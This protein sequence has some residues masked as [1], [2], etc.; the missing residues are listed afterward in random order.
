MVEIGHLNLKFQLFQD[1][2]WII[3]MYRHLSPWPYRSAV[4]LWPVLAVVLDQAVVQH[5]DA[6]NLPLPPSA[7]LGA[8]AR[9]LLGGGVLRSEHAEGR[10]EDSHLD[11]THKARRH[12]RLQGGPSPCKIYRLLTDY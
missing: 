4:L 6:R 9:R 2:F 10:W 11:R 12:A 8:T 3:S 7:T 5:V 1:K